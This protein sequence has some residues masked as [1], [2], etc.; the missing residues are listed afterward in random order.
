[1]RATE[2][3]TVGSLRQAVS[4]SSHQETVLARLA[5]AVAVLMLMITVASLLVSTV[6][7]MMERR[8]PI[9]VL[10]A[11]GV[12][13]SVIRRSVILQILLPLSIA[14]ALGVAVALAVTVLVFGILKE[15]L[16][17]PLR[18]L[19]LTAVAV[20]AAVMVVTSS[21]LPWVRVARRPELLRT[22]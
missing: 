9:A 5:V 20:G 7:G 2:V 14:L 12:P 4:P 18:P 11:L 19:T 22:E 8:R 17:L 6:D 15:P 3:R 16:L 21:A 1:W 10:S 13:A